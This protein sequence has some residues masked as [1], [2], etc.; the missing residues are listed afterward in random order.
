[1]GGALALAHDGIDDIVQEL[2]RDVRGTPRKPTYH[3]HVAKILEKHCTTCHH[4]GD[5]A[6]MSLD[7]F[8]DAEFWI[9][10]ALEEIAKGAMPPWRPTRGV[11]KFAGERGLSDR[12]ISTLVRWHEQGAPAGR[13]PRKPKLPA[14]DSGWILGEPDVVYE[15]GQPFQVP[16]TGDDIYRCFPIQ[17]DFN[18]DVYVRAIDVQPGDRRIVHHVVLYIDTVGESHELDAAE[19]GPGYICFGGPGLSAFDEF[20]D[21]GNIEGLEI[22]ASPV[23]GGWAPGNRPAFFPRDRGIRIPAGATIVMQ[24]HYHPLPGQPLPDAT[25]FGLYLSDHPDPQEVV[26]LP[27]VN[28]DFTIPAG[29]AYHEVTAELDPRELVREATGLNLDLSAEIMAVLPHMHLLGREISVDLDLPDGTSQR[30]VEI[31]NWSFDW[32]DTYAFKKAVPAPVGSSLRM[33]CVFDN[34]ADNPLNP[35]VPPQPVSWG[36][37]TVDEMALAFVA[38]TLRF[39]DDFLDLLTLIG[40]DHPHP[41][42]LRAIRANR[43]PVVRRVRI[44]ARGRLQVQAARLAGGGRI[45]IDGAAVADSVQTGRGARRLRSEHD[46]DELTPA[47]TPVQI[48]VRRAD[49][50]LSQPYS[51]TR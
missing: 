29:D 43:P 5:I 36:E 17:T 3:R 10:E 34:S 13:A 20:F 9:D 31:T 6:P 33:R 47:G 42:G 4:E 26:L 38:L 23:L 32:Q 2:P 25:K 7:N 40:R 27:L 14:Y 39:P 41:K 12:E 22:P 49:G 1:L 37:R 46:W 19:P 35:N 24:L 8:A 50:R 44:D 11:G 51:F 18:E 30:L 28:M 16:G 45:E 48:T 15:Y 21:S